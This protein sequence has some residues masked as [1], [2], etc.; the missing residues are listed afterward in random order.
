MRSFHTFPHRISLQKPP[1]RGSRM[2]AAPTVGVNRL[3]P[4]TPGNA[5]EL[6]SSEDDAPLNSSHCS[7]D[8]RP[9]S[10][11]KTTARP[12]KSLTWIWKIGRGPPRPRRSAAPIHVALWAIRNRNNRRLARMSAPEEILLVGICAPTGNNFHRARI[13][14]ERHITTNSFRD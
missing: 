14:R 12:T 7:R 8:Q 3:L 13:R 6:S 11:K 2:F 1:P 10:E 4:K 5:I 9:R